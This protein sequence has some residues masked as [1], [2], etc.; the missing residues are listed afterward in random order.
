MSSSKDDIETYTTQDSDNEVNGSE[1][2]DMDLKEILSEFF[3]ESKKNRN[4]PEIFLE[5]KRTIDVHNKLMM[6][7]IQAIQSK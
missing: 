6:Q 5:I 3:L 1:F 4:L 7:L 2:E